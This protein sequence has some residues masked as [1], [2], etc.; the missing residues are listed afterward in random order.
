MDVVADLRLL[1]SQRRIANPESKCILSLVGAPFSSQT[2]L[3][4]RETKVKWD[5]TPPP[6]ESNTQSRS[7]RKIKKKHDFQFVEGDVE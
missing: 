1:A 4:L 7:G 2:F 6:E 3:S 5:A